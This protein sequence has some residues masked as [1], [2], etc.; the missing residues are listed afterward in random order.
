MEFLHTAFKVYLDGIEVPADNVTISVG[1]DQPS[2]ATFYIHPTETAFKIKNRTLVH[3]S[4]K[5][6]SYRHNLQEQPSAVTVADEQTPINYEYYPE[7][8]IFEGEIIQKNYMESRAQ[9]AINILATDYRNLLDTP[10][11]YFINIEDAIQQTQQIALNGGTTYVAGILDYKTWIKHKLETHKNDFQALMLSFFETNSNNFFKNYME[12]RKFRMR[13]Y[14]DTGRVVRT[15]LMDD[16][17]QE[18]LQLRIQGLEGT[19]VSFNSIIGSISSPIIQTK[20]LNFITNLSPPKF[21]S[22]TGDGTVLIKQ[23]IVIP[24]LV[25]CAPPKCNVFFPSNIGSVSYVDSIKFSRARLQ[26]EIFGF[27]TQGN[28]EVDKNTAE[29]YWAPATLADKIHDHL[30]NHGGSLVQA[31]RTEM[32]DEE[33]QLGIF[34]ISF[35]VPMGAHAFSLTNLIDYAFKLH[36]FAQN[37][38]ILS[39]CPFNPFPVVGLPAMVMLPHLIGIGTIESITHHLGV[40]N[41]SSDFTISNFV[42]YDEIMQTP[43]LLADFTPDK[44]D[45]VY[46]EMLA[47]K[48]IMEYDNT[49]HTVSTAMT[50]VKNWYQGLPLEDVFDHVSQF[51]R[52]PM[53]T[54]I[55]MREFVL[56]GRSQTHVVNSGGETIQSVSY[57]YFKT[58]DHWAD[59]WNH[60]LNESSRNSVNNNPSAKLKVGSSWYIPTL[61]ASNPAA[62]ETDIDLIRLYVEECNK[63][64]GN[65][66][67]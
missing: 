22:S 21:I 47:C 65:S 43:S 42:P 50:A 52:R 46:L 40:K 38:V 2:T 16:A 37:R 11:L 23:F 54:S 41:Q 20:L 64:K 15:Q 59:I 33:T 5:T 63:F 55:E 48:S 24:N 25:S 61:T 62:P 36:R 39:N 56:K 66:S 57:W 32:T 29:E 60:P 30:K 27:N 1:I 53:V 6:T 17:M 28:P 10:L 7:F 34:P 4:A 8:A 51:N 45:N 35:T 44:I 19:T 3:I 9:S 58:T 18:I 67:W 12:N 26:R 13:F 31:A 14:T 49:A